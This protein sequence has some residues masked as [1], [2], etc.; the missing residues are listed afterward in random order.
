VKAA[1]ANLI[2][3]MRTR[4]SVRRFRSEHP[5]RERIAELIELAST[6]PSASNKQPW[7][8][9]VADD[10]ALIARMAAK[11]QEAIDRIIPHIAEQFV[12]SFRAYGDYFVRFSAAP[13]VIAPVCRETP[14]LAHLVDGSL[15]DSDAQHVKYME[16]MSPVLSCGLA[17]QNLLLAAHAGGL[18]ASCMTGPLV[19]GDELKSLLGIPPSWQLTCLVAVGFPDESP[20]ATTRKELNHVL[21]WVEPGVAEQMERP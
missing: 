11:V 18:G 15:S 1:A 17:V 12:P 9:F 19:A 6:A 16:Q 3:I 13:V 10:G 2:D 5:G 7:R 4:R 14:V 21:R 8:F 20:S